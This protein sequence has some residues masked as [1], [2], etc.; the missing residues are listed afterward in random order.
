M[1]FN[2]TESVTIIDDDDLI[3]IPT[4]NGTDPTTV[5]SHSSSNNITNNTATIDKS[6]LTYDESLCSMCNVKKIDTTSDMD[7]NEIN[8]LLKF[9]LN[10]IRAWV[11]PQNFK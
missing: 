10:R 2:S 9:V 5:D 1:P 4:T 8:Y 11:S 7:K 3:N 6:T